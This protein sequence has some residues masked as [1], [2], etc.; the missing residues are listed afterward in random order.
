MTA[1]AASPVE[2]VLSLPLE[3]QEAVLLALL[4]KL[5]VVCEGQGKIPIHTPDGRSLGYL[6]PPWVEKEQRE[7]FFASMTPDERRLMTEPLDA[8]EVN[9]CL[10]PDEVKAIIE[11]ERRGGRSQPAAAPLQTTHVA[12][13]QPDISR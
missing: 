3:D 13:F 8:G 12:A 10:T 4:D 11:R 1:T 5:L 9:D 2:H 6:T 7:A